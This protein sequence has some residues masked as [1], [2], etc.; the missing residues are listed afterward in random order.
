MNNQPGSLSPSQWN[1]L[2]E[3]LNDYIKKNEL[4]AFYQTIKQE[5]GFKYPTLAM[6]IVTMD[7]IAGQVAVSY[8]KRQASNAGV[9]MSDKQIDNVRNAM[10]TGYLGALNAK[11][12]RGDFSDLKWNEA[13]ELHNQ[14]FQDIGL[15]PTAW[16]LYLPFNT[17]SAASAADYWES[18]LSSTESLDLSNATSYMDTYLL[19]P[20]STYFAGH[21]V[22]L[23]A[24]Y[25]SYMWWLSNTFGFA[26]SAGGKFLNLNES[27]AFSLQARKL[28]GYI[29]LYRPADSIILDETNFEQATLK[30]WSTFSNDSLH[31][32]SVIPTL[33]G[34]SAATL[35][36]AL[37]DNDRGAHLRAALRH[38]A[39]A[40]IEG[41]DLACSEVSLIN[42]R[43]GAGDVN[44]SWLQDRVALL[45]ALLSVP[46][47]VSAK[48]P[49]AFVDTETGQYTITSPE[50]YATDNGRIVFGSLDV[51]NTIEGSK[52]SDRLY[53]GLE[54][55]T[56]HAGAADDVLYGFAGIDHL[57]GEAGKD[58]LDGG[59]GDDFLEGGKGD[60]QLRGGYGTDTYIFSI[61]DGNDVIEDIDGLGVIQLAGF[62]GAGLIRVS[63]TSYIWRT[64]DNSI[65]VSFSGSSLTESGELTISYGQSDTVIIKD[66]SNGKLGVNLP[67]DSPTPG[68]PNA[69]GLAIHG[70]I[71][72]TADSNFDSQ[73]NIL[74]PLH[75]DPG[76]EDY[77]FGSDGADQIF[78]WD[79]DDSIRGG[80]GNDYIEGGDG[81]NLINGNSGNDTIYAGTRVGISTINDARIPTDRNA[82]LG[83][84]VSAD[85]GDD[86][87]IGSEISDLLLGGEGDDIIYGGDGN[88]VLAGDTDFTLGSRVQ[89][90]ATYDSNGR[91]IVT[92][93]SWDHRTNDDVIGDDTLYGGNG[94]DVILGNGGNDTIDGGEGNDSLDGGIG[95][96]VVFGGNGDDIIRGG[97]KW[98]TSPLTNNSADTNRLYGENGNDTVSGDDGAD[99]IDG[100]DGNDRLYGNDESGFAGDEDRDVMYGGKGNDIVSGLEGDDKLYGGEGDDILLGGK[101]SDILMG[102]QGADQLYGGEGDD[103]L[104]GGEGADILSGDAGNDTYSVSFGD[105]VRDN[106]GDSNVNLQV[107][108]D[109]SAIRIHSQMRGADK[110]ATIFQDDKVVGTFVGNLESFTFNFLNGKTFSFLDLVSQYSIISPD[111][112]Y[113]VMDGVTV[114]TQFSDNING[115]WTSQIFEGNRGDDLIYGHGGDDVFK[116]NFGDGQDTI[117]QEGG[118]FTIQLGKGIALQD[119]TQQRLPDGSLSLGFADG[120][121]LLISNYFGLAVPGS[122]VFADG[123]VLNDVDLRK[124]TSAP[125]YGTPVADYLVGSV[126]ADVIYGDEGNDLID[127]HGGDDDVYGGGGT[128]TYVFGSRTGELTIHEDA[129]STSIIQLSGIERDSIQTHREGYDLVISSTQGNGIARVVDYYVAPM[130]IRVQ[131]GDVT[132][133]IGALAEANVVHQS[134]LMP[135]DRFHTAFS[136]ATLADLNGYLERLGDL[137]SVDGMLVDRVNHSQQSYTYRRLPGWTGDVPSNWSYESFSSLNVYSVVNARTETAVDGQFSSYELSLGSSSGQAPIGAVRINGQVSFSKP[138]TTIGSEAWHQVVDESM[139]FFVPKDPGSV[140]H[141]LDLGSPYVDYEQLWI[142][143]YRHVDTYT[144]ETVT[145]SSSG[146]FTNLHVS[147]TDRWE[148]A[149]VNGNEVSATGYASEIG[150]RDVIL[151]G[152]DN[153][154]TFNLYSWNFSFNFLTLNSTSRL[155]DSVSVYGGDGDDVIRFETYG[156]DSRG[157]GAFLA[158]EGGNDTIKGTDFA[159]WIIGGTGNDTL[160]GGSGSDIYVFSK[161]DVGYSDTIDDQGAAAITE[162]GY[163]RFAQDVVLFDLGISKDDVAFS[164][165]SK[166]GSN[167]KFLKVTWAASSDIFIPIIADAESIAKGIGVEEFR[168]ADGSTISFNDALSLAKDEVLS[169]LGTVI[170]S[171]EQRVEFLS[172]LTTVC[173]LSLTELKAS[174]GNNTEIGSLKFNILTGGELTPV[175][176]FS[177]VGDR[178]VASGFAMEDYG[179]SLGGKLA[180]GWQDVSLVITAQDPTGAVKSLQVPVAIASYN[181]VA[182]EEEGANSIGLSDVRNVISPAHSGTAVGSNL[183]DTLNLLNGGVVNADGADGGDMYV[184]G[185]AEGYSTTINDTGLSGN[186]SVFVYDVDYMMGKGASMYLDM[187]GDSLVISSLSSESEIVVEH[188]SQQSDMTITAYNSSLGFEQVNNLVHALAAFSPASGSEGHFSDLQKGEI[189]QLVIAS[190]QESKYTGGVV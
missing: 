48:T 130:E 125:I 79:G 172:G 143:I 146:I 2:R 55:D 22:G 110:Y 139:Y 83:S 7:T 108:F 135:L 19:L 102:D 89:W 43:T 20:I 21:R 15:P 124:V 49:F 104:D 42:E 72:N 32:L 73:G 77:L 68:E 164:V 31:A 145:T 179:V 148:S 58:A 158:G 132:T 190:F 50:G 24:E 100:G 56:I 122:V 40:Y 29:D 28:E 12:N 23:V 94:D 69:T 184:V 126:S 141:K 45:E 4:A 66:F 103:V 188:W 5:T 181:R 14:A 142:P 38:L 36:A 118:T 106:D 34:G 25:D 183:S 37:A 133:E 26:Q 120:G 161:E 71:L 16:T 99:I 150:I 96:D 47:D 33:D 92:F 95:D 101:G 65:I 82:V 90:D 131:E 166:E 53:G 51:A 52:L 140:E 128:D 6:G 168:F 114:G 147:A 10:A 163:D 177:I 3:R 167:G 180:Q 189:S 46:R 121:S 54:A 9:A 81:R 41:L 35:D 111:A 74:G 115:D 187:E 17:L 61:G 173:E 154:D 174:F 13:L 39:P 84:A 175:D 76:K 8:M 153:S 186:D 88:D 137:T 98:K 75:S 116:Y 178:L 151:R 156:S 117:F 169:S 155:K 63:D 109:A 60:D 165:V 57:Y 93:P 62:S 162:F 11:F 59:T 105:V 91:V 44:Q 185:L 85:G 129:G 136:S 97:G 176:S 171:I 30:F 80:S 64:L 170:Q 144:K 152:G 107:A 112:N 1:E 149:V 18:I 160:D 134:Q 86:L 113:V 123:T 127:G 182:G 87:V 70:D 27:Q 159:D 138:A 67:E 119:V 157:A 78:G